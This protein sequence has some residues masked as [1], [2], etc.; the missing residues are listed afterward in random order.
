VGHT[1][2]FHEP[3]VFEIVD[4][5]TDGGLVETGQVRQLSLQGGS[6]IGECDQD[7]EVSQFQTVRAHDDSQRGRGAAMGT[8]GE[9]PDGERRRIAWPVCG[10]I[11]D[12]V[13]SSLVHHA[14]IVH[15]SNY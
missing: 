11:T 8:S 12:R 3:C 9:Q 13:A 2:T 6:A 14:H 4:T 1:D 5:S 10:S 7:G 15:G